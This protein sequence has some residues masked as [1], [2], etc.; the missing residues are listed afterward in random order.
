MARWLGRQWGRQQPAVLAE[1]FTDDG[2]IVRVAKQQAAED[3][4][5][6]HLGIN[7][8][9]IPKGF[10]GI[11]LVSRLPKR[12]GLKSQHGA[13][14]LFGVK[15]HGALGE[16]AIV[17]ALL[18]E[19]QGH[20]AMTLRP[21]GILRNHLS[22]QSGGALDVT[23]AQKPRGQ[24]LARP[25]EVRIDLQDLLPAGPWRAPSLRLD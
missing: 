19:R 13:G 4:R 21:L 1:E 9:R 12:D 24:L 20:D 3:I 10:L 16:R 17:I 15:G 2:N 7:F 23:P 6:S 14:I 22:R 5:R 25:R 11:L 18:P 8:C